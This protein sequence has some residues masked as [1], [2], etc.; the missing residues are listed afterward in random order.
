[1]QVRTHHASGG[2]S[3]SNSECRMKN[4]ERKSRRSGWVRASG[5]ASA[6][7]RLLERTARAAL[8]VEQ[9]PVK[10]LEI[11]VIDAVEMKRQHKQWMGDGS[12]TDVLTFDLRE[13]GRGPIEGQ[14]LVCVD[15]A[16]RRAGPRGDWRRELALYVVHGCLH[17]CGYDDH[18]P[19]DFK[20]MHT[21]EDEILE[22]LGLGRVF[23]DEGALRT[24]RASRK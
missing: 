15:V 10:Q 17:L 20:K 4:V 13:R 6:V 12:V 16:K 18:D 7:C 14:I 8:A 3:A 23:S 1:M 2:T 11:A 22:S 24:R 19:R 9:A 5:A 21:R